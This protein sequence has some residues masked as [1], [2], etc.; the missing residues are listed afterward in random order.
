MTI[1]EEKNKAGKRVR[2]PVLNRVVREGLTQ[3]GDGTLREAGLMGKHSRRR[4]QHV[5]CFSVRMRLL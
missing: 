1:A 5:Q 4:Q 3:E 2:K